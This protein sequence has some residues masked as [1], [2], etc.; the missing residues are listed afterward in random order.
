MIDAADHIRRL[1]DLKA[2]LLILRK[3]APRSL[4]ATHRNL[5]HIAESR[6]EEAIGVAKADLAGHTPTQGAV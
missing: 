2:E 1:E 4:S 3:D 5:L 6:I